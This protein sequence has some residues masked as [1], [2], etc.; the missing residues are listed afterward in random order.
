MT[1]PGEAIA[2]A[3]LALAGLLV[4]RSLGRSDD[5]APAPTAPRSETT[6]EA[7]PVAN[8]RIDLGRPRRW[9]VGDTVTIRGTYSDGWLTPPRD[10][11]GPYPDAPAP[12]EAAPVVTSWTAIHQCVSASADGSSTDMLVHFRE[13]TQRDGDTTDQSLAGTLIGVGGS[14]WD[15]GWSVR[16]GDT[17]LSEAARSWLHERYGPSARPRPEECCDAVAYPPGPVA[18]GESWSP[19]MVRLCAWHNVADAPSPKDV[20]PISAT[21]TLAGVEGEPGGRIARIELRARLRYQKPMLL[22]P[23]ESLDWISGGEIEISYSLCT[24][25]PGNDA[26]TRS[27]FAW[28]S[29]GRWGIKSMRHA[30]GGPAEPYVRRGWQSFSDWLER[31]VARGG[32]IPV[33]PPASASTGR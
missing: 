10:V 23:A 4:Y 12:A 18:V 8:E 15:R 1:R 16:A 22:M 27:R 25:L 26:P 24:P 6:S 30:E 29:G 3:A 14:G 2:A 32:E 13:W 19:D 21:A 9:Q 20:V 11:L 31:S 17:A 33:L 5:L 7:A 28:S